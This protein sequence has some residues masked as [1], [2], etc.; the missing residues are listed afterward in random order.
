MKDIYAE[1]HVE[2]HVYTE[3]LNGSTIFL[4]KVEQRIAYLDFKFLN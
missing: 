1:V 3:G 2:I 4:S